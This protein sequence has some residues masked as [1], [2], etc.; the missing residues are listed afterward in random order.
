CPRTSR[1]AGGLQLPVLKTAADA[2][3]AMSV[4]TAAISAGT[5]TVQQARD[6]TDIVDAFRKTHELADIERR[7]VALERET[8]PGYG[9]AQK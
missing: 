9:P 3:A 1:T 4:I 6:L 8:E 2:V 5:I 7:I